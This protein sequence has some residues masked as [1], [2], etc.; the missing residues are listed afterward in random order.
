MVVAILVTGAGTQAVAPFIR[1]DDF[2]YQLPSGTPGVPDVWRRN[3]LEGRWL[4]YAWWL[5]VGQHST[6][7]IASLTYVT[8]YV[9]LVAG[10]WR[11]LRLTLPPLHWGVEAL[12]GLSVFVSPI[13]VQLFYWPATLTP[14]T[15]LGAVAV[16]LLPAAA[17]RRMWL[18]VW[19]AVAAM[20]SVL[21]YPPVGVVLFLSAVVTLVR[22][23][24]R[25]V[26]WLTGAFLGGFAVGLILLNTLNLLDFGH[27]GLR[28]SAWRRPNPV[29]DL[30]DLRVNGARFVR[31]L[32]ALTRQQWLPVVVGMAAVAGGLIDRRVRP[33]M[34]RLLFGLAVVLGLSLAQ[35]L[36]TGVL[37]ATRGELWVWLAALLPSV[38]LLDG[39]RPARLAGLVGIV[40]LTVVG[41]TAWRQDIGAHQRTRAQYAAIVAEAVRPRADGS[42]PVVV[43]YQDPALRAGV[44]GGTMSGIMRMMLRGELGGVP[45]W[46]ARTEC[47]ELAKAAV[48]NGV[49]ATGATPGPPESPEQASR[50]VVDLGNVRGV[51][52]PSI[53]PW[54]R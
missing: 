46:C 51:L 15:V 1:L 2:T 52:V 35:T 43:I 30:H 16:W 26:F 11:V 23:R 37:T 17:R 38:L 6:P 49:E 14:S 42:V 5:L 8:A 33:R 13:W 53:P 7:L 21:T 12:L 3:L 47:D 45:R 40:V 25:E 4:T 9:G 41:V 31:N 34:L 50:F 28:I 32:W 48:R 44:R 39:S 10:L 36:A 19:M 29:H 54:W 22:R 20:L 24:W 18:L 27:F